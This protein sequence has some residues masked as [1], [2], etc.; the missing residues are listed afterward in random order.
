MK[1]NVCYIISSLSNEGPTNVLYNIIKYMDFD[2]FRVS[3]VTMI[4]EKENSRWEDFQ[5][6]NIRIVPL[7]SEKALNPIAMFMRLREVIKGLNPDILHTHCARSMFLVPFLSSRYKKVETVHIYPGIQQEVK[8]GKWKGKLVNALSHFFTMRM[9]LPIAC[10]ESVA[11]S[12]WENWHFRMMAIPNGCSLPVWTGDE[13]RRKLIRNQIGLREDVR[14][15]LFIG[16]FSREKNPDRI[17]QAFEAMNDPGT[18]VILLGEGALYE[19]LKHHETDRILLPGF[20]PNVHDYVLASDYYISA[21]D[22]EGLANTLLESMSV[23]LPCVLSDIPSHH[24]V[25]DKA[26]R[27]MAFLYDQHDL[28]AMTKAIRDVLQLD[29]ANTGAYIRS[30]YAK[31][32]TAER[33]SKSYQKAYIRLIESNIKKTEKES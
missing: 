2:R 22:T 18:G 11:Q 21:S 24:E 17:V 15:F 32:Y 26:E 1:I 5:R 8:F 31:Y 7:S 19:E 28:S 23:G 3:L 25:V 12:Y 6:L 10:S 4:P 29:R 20:K 27:P 30:L 9:D 14:Y 33:M 13:E 16:R